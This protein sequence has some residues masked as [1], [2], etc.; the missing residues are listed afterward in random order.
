MRRLGLFRLAVVVFGLCTV[1]MAQQFRISEYDV[2]TI[3]IEYPPSFDGAEAWVQKYL[4]YVF[5]GK[6]DK[7]GS[8]RYK[9]LFEVDAD[10]MALGTPNNARASLER[11][12]ELAQGKA[13]TSRKRARRCLERYVH[14]DIRP[15]GKNWKAWYELQRDRIAFIES[16]GFWWQENPEVLEREA[17]ARRQDR[18]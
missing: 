11:W 10:A 2:D 6:S 14:P 17:A 4:P 9:N 8:A 15:K 1:A 12:I 18:R 16:T 7:H 13:G 5:S 3:T